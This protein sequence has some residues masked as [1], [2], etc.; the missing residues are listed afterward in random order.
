MNAF[1]F[2]SSVLFSSRATIISPKTGSGRDVMMNGI[3]GQESLSLSST[4]SICI[5]TLPELTVLSH[6]PIMRNCFL[7]FISTRSLVWRVPS[8]S[9]GATI[10]RVEM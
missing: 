2:N 6:L 7:S 5:F 1:F 4:S 3:E 8:W 9:I 10:V